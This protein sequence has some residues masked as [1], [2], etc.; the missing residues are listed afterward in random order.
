MILIAIL[1]Q[2]FSEVEKDS[3]WLFFRVM[4]CSQT[5]KRNLTKC[6]KFPSIYISSNDFLAI[7][8]KVDTPHQAARPLVDNYHHALSQV[9]YLKFP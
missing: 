7:Q 3:F 5:L 8:A 9:A 6:I 1:F 2:S 4:I